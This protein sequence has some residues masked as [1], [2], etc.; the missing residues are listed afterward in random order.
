MLVNVTPHDLTILSDAGSLE[1][2]RSGHVARVKVER[3]LVE[4]IGTFE[5]TRAR[6]GELEGLPEA[7]EG[8]VYVA[9]LL[10]AQA[11]AAIGRADVL[12]PGELVRDAA[13]QPTG[14][15]GLTRP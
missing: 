8:V 14:C 1:L 11:A 12:A 10:A 4:V 9:S 5:V 15:R 6:F 13:G 3:E 2:P 7:A